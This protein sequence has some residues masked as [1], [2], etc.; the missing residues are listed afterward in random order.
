MWHRWRIFLLRRRRGCQSLQPVVGT[1]RPASLL[2]ACPENSSQD[3]P[4]N[5]VMVRPDRAGKGGA[6]FLKLEGGSVKGAL[7][8][9]RLARVGRMNGAESAGEDSVRRPWQ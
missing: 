5:S 2:R 8:E 7:R 1:L 9:A 4:L 3:L 6:L